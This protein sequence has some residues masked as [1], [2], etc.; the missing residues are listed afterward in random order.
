[1][2]RSLLYITISRLGISFS[3][4]VCVRF[5]CIPKES[6]PTTIKRILK[7]L[8]AIIDFEMLFF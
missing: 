5:Q 8:S 3:V 7:Y 1:M 4:G 6:H 2:I